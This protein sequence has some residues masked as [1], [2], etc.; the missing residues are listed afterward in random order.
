MLR[1]LHLKDVGPAARFDLDLGERLNVLTGD[2]GLGKSFVL[3][4]AWWALTGSWVGKLMLPQPGKEDGAEIGFDIG[5]GE[6]H[7]EGTA[8]FARATQNWL[9]PALRD[10][11]AAWPL[12]LYVRADGFSVWDPARNYSVRSAVWGAMKPAAFHFGSQELWYGLGLEGKTLCN[13][14]I[15]DWVTW[16]LEARDDEQHPFHLL[17]HLLK[18]LSHPDE[19]MVPGKP[20]RVYHDDVLK[21]P[22]I[23]LPYG[24][25]PVIHASEGMKR[26]LGLSYLLAWAWTEHVAESKTVGRTAPSSIVLLMDEIESHLHPRWQRHVLPALLH[27]LEGL[28][29]GVKPQILV[30]THSPLVLASLE[31]EFDPARDKQLL[32]ELVDRQVTLRE[33]P[34]AKRGDAV[35]WL[36]SDVFGL[37]QGGSI[38]ADRAIE[39]AHRL[40]EG[41]TADLAE[42]LRT[43][44]EI[45]R[46]LHRVLPDQHPL[47]ADWYAFRKHKIA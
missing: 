19:P 6:Q 35:S 18:S 7:A 41:D 11:S 17:V 3:D 42:G 31:T 40:I 15:R 43:E 13:G 30:T 32:F 44:E 12:V 37:E 9:D 2:N 5:L 21:Y 25:L 28:G 47:L 39:A 8:T 34:W 36:T 10:A 14:L 29:D 27:V 20:A 24:S 46:E 22:T 16:Q 45:D 23:E 4:V 1:S 26:I 33:L 38:P